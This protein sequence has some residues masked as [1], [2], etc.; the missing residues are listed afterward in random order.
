MNKDEKILVAGATGMV[1]SAI[2]RNL[3]AKGY[4][5]ILTPD[6]KREVIIQISI[7]HISIWIVLDLIM[8]FRT[9]QSGW[10]Y[11]QCHTHCRLY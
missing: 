2:V 10:N 4:T 6:R 1:G 5:N 3:K 11:G 8:S 9:C 7:I